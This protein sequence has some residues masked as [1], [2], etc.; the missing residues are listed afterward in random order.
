MEV[1][2]AAG[3]S[4]LYAAKA[5]VRCYAENGSPGANLNREARS[6]R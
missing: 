5:E 6:A 4:K 1:V 3:E 2:K